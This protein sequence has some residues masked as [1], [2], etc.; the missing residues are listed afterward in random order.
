MLFQSTIFAG[1]AQSF[2]QKHSYF[3]RLLFCLF[4]ICFYPHTLTHFLS[5]IVLDIIPLSL[6]ICVLDSLLFLIITTMSV[7]IG[8]CVAL[9]VGLRVIA[10]V[11]RRSIIILLAGVGICRNG[12]VIGS[13]ATIRLTV[14]L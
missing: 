10:C 1:F 4:W 5:Q 8:L 9:R 11:T 12:T 6:F 2:S 14:V 13:G 3:C 7:L